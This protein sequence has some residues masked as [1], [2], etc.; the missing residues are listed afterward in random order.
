MRYDGKKKKMIRNRRSFGRRV[1]VLKR[2]YERSQYNKNDTLPALMAQ[3][4]RR[5]RFDTFVQTAVRWNQ[6]HMEKTTNT[7]RTMKNVWRRRA[8]RGQ[9]GRYGNREQY[10]HE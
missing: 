5:R 10:E 1:D 9:S 2:G 7:H 4:R 8:G 6:N 3:R